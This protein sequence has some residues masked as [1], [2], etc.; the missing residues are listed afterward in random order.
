M[1][2]EIDTL[3]LDQNNSDKWLVLMFSCR[4][5][6][7]FRPSEMEQKPGSDRPEIMVWSWALLFMS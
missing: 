1:F 6:K 2:Q 5:E 7:T 3:S 4:T